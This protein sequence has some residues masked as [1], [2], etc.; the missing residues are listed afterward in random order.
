MTGW[1][2]SRVPMIRLAGIYKGQR[3]LFDAKMETY[4]N[5]IDADIS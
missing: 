3:P 4:G 5:L 2:I 1:L